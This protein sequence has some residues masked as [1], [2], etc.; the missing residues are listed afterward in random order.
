MRWLPEWMAKKRDLIHSD[1]REPGR[2]H[3]KELREKAN[4]GS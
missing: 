1:Y 2:V 3:L 4:L